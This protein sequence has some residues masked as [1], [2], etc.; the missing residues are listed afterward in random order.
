MHQNLLSFNSGELSP[1]LAHRVD[2]A[3]HA[4]GSSRM[5]NFLPMPYGSFQKRPGTRRMGVALRQRAFLQEVTFGTGD[6]AVTYRAKAGVIVTVSHYPTSTHTLTSYA[7]VLEYVDGQEEIRIRPASSIAKMLVTGPGQ[8][9][10]GHAD[11]FPE[12]LYAGTLVAGPITDTIWSSTGSQTAPGSGVWYVA[13]ARALTGLNACYVSRYNNGVATLTCMKTCTAG[14]RPPEI[15]WTG[16]SVTTGTL[17]AGS[18]IGCQWN[19]LCTAA[20]LVAAVNASSGAAAL[21]V[22]SYGGSGTG[23]APLDCGPVRLV[24]SNALGEVP[25]L[26]D[27]HEALLPF[28][29]AGGEKYLLHFLPGWIEVLREDGSQAAAMRWLTGY[30]WPEGQHPAQVQVVQLNDVAFIS[31]PAHAPMQI[32]R[33]GDA[34]WTLDWLWFTAAPCLDDNTNPARTYSIVSNPVPA[35]YATGHSY[36]VG[37]TC[38]TDSEWVCIQSVSDVKPGVGTEWKTYWKR[39]LF[40]KGDPVTLISNNVQA[41]E[42]SR[43]FLPYN[44]GTIVQ[45]WLTW[46]VTSIFW[47]VCVRNTW[48]SDAG[49]AGSVS[50]APATGDWQVVL[51]YDVTSTT[52]ILAGAYRLSAGAD[53]GVYKLKSSASPHVPLYSGHRPGLDS[54]WAVDWDLVVPDINVYE[55]SYN[56]SGWYA[57]GTEVSRDGGLYRCVRNHQPTVSNEPGG[58]GDWSSYWERVDVFGSD[59]SMGVRGPGQ[60]YKI[61][62][63]RSQ[64]EAQ[65]ELSAIV[66]HDGTHSEAIVMQGG[67]DLYT[68]GTWYGTFTLE[69]STDGGT[70]WTVFRSWQASG[71]RNVAEAGTEEE[72]VML[73]IGFISQVGTGTGDG[74]TGTRTTGDQRAVLIPRLPRVTGYALL[75]EYVSATEMRGFAATSVLSGNTWHWAQGAFSDN[76][77]YPAAACLHER[78]LF[79]AGTSANPVSLWGSS[80]DDMNHFETGTKD[81]DGIFVSLAAN[82][83]E[84]IRWMASQRSLFLGTPSGEWTCGTDPAYMAYTAPAALTPTNFQCRQYTAFGSSTLAPIKVAGALIFAGRNGSRLWELSFSSNGSAGG[85]LSR[86][87]EHLT[88]KGIVSLARQAVRTPGLWA[89]TADGTLLHLCHDP[90]EELLAWSRHTTLNGLFRSVAVLPSQDGDDGVF[91]LVERGDTTWLEAIP[92]GWQAAREAGTPDAVVDA[93]YLYLGS[94]V[95]EPVTSTLTLLPID[96]TDPQTGQPTAARAKRANEMVLNLLASQGGSVVYDGQDCPLDYFGVDP[97]T[98]WLRVTLS[99]AHV[100]DLTPSIVHA[101]SDPFTCLAVVVRW[102]AHEP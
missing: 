20:Q 89:A 50:D 15:S 98:G 97:F 51:H 44:A 21:V 72:P 34:D 35:A 62:P 46:D 57:V 67:W 19:G 17:P 1:Y 43:L 38:R 4:A 32:F 102:S 6:S 11:T 95:G 52:G 5:E 82:A 49:V 25:A 14:L 3:K 81:T 64:F 70:N 68:F 59:T 10:L 28:V 56:V 54:T 91:F 92:Q 30:A 33:R 94:Y 60:Y 58:S 27:R 13:T 2:F 45:T 79:F 42:W 31:H 74:G 99:P 18:T 84:P 9:G 83:S 76:N 16:F 75:N 26:Y 55:A 23:L 85:D 61:S 47:V 37:N 90:S 93:A 8:D 22:A 29:A 71:D 87:A 73:R 78:R 101:T 69:R 24:D 7:E 41:T 80:T 65:V 100:F 96:I 77:G 40:A 63:E 86:Y 36:T 66:D 12:L 48:G 88:S 53:M 39:R